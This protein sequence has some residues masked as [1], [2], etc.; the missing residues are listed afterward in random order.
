M[1]NLRLMPANGKAATYSANGRTYT[2]A[3]GAT[4]DVIDFDAYPMTA[5]GWVVMAQLVGPTSARPAKPSPG[6]AF[7]DTTLGIT[8]VHEGTAWRNP[9]TGGVV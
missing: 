9:A 2:C 5:N 4:I 1:P 7:H 3:A 6:Q 8:I